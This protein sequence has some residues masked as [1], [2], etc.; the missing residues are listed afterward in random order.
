M[1]YLNYLYKIAKVKWLETHIW[2]SKRMKMCE[3]WGYKLV[4]IYKYFLLI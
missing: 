2:H 1:Y 4:N 3:K